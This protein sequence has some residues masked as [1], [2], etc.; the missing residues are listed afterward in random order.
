M[1]EEKKL[2]K[3]IKNSNTKNSSTGKNNLKN[4]SNI[5]SI[6]DSKIK[7]KT[8]AIH[9]LIIKIQ[10]MEELFRNLKNI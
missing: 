6:Q 9:V 5:K 3:N 10:M 8:T 1:K 7:N 2:K 4:G